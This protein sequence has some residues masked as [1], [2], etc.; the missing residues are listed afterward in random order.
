MESKYL[1]VNELAVLLKINKNWIY[2]R[3]RERGPDSIPHLRLG[4]F[5][6]FD[7]K[8]ILEWLKKKQQ[9]RV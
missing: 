3:T 8:S 9:E 2:S 4:K 5:I 1:T 7:E 6:R